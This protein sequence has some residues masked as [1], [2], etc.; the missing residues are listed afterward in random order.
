MS[1]SKAVKIFELNILR[2]AGVAITPQQVG[3]KSDPIADLQARNSNSV[4]G[5]ML[6][7]MGMTT[8]TPPTPP[9]D[10]TDT[11]AV[12]TYHQELLAY[13]QNMQMYNQRFM[14]MM[15]TQMQNMQQ[16]MMR[17]QQS[18]SATSS[19]TSSSN[20]DLGIGGIL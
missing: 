12:N 19:S 7:R 4:F 17:S 1:F 8:P 3:L 16:S 18:Q 11:T 14:Q 20:I 5:T 6:S 13:S 2:Q 15:L 9:T 10:L